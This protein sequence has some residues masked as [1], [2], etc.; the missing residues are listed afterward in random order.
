M[1]QPSKILATVGKMDLWPRRETPVIPKSLH[2]DW[3]FL[4]ERMIDD[5]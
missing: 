1:E 5:R 2:W 3:F 4:K